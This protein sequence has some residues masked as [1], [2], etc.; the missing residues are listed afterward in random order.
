M[1]RRILIVQNQV[2]HYRK[3]LYNELAQYYEVTIFHSGKPSVET[4]DFYK[5]VISSTINVGPFFI[6]KSL[7]Q[8][9]CKG[10]FAIVFMADLH[11]LLNV[12][13]PLFGNLLIKGKIIL[14]G[15]WFTNK[16]VVDRFKILL[17]KRVDGNIFYCQETKS[18]FASAG[19]NI[20]KLFVAN[21]TVNVH[22]R[23]KS[24]ENDLKRR[25]VF[26]G[27][28]NKRKQNDVLINAF[29][30]IIEEIAPDIVLTFIGDGN[31]KQELIEL[32]QKLNIGSRVS[33]I[34][35]TSNSEILSEYYR[36]ALVSVSYGQAGLSVLQSFGFG[37]P[38]LTKKNAI[39]GG[40]T[41]NI[42]NGYNG[43]L[44]SDNENDFRSK[45]FLFC[46]DYKLAREMGKN[47]YDYYTEFCTIG[48]MADGFIDAIGN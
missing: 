13:F 4:T 44:C 12:I 3:A 29:K 23:A 30:N 35:A 43:Y 45:L 42:I 16:K 18:S 38:F 36:E 39:S 11:W 22:N 28:L 2:P 8:E 25:I 46:S 17:A 40:E 10:Y 6:Q 15:S 41:S 47:A 9:I 14:W 27:T 34:E 21:N 48:K 31:M 5:E 32:V 33:F 26:V 19:V 7:Y 1:E 20:K 24:Y 37:V